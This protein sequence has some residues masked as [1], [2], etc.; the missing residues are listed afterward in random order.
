MMNTQ[1]SITCKEAE[2]AVAT[3][4]ALLDPYGHGGHIVQEMFAAVSF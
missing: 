1:T 2:L 4:F 3:Y